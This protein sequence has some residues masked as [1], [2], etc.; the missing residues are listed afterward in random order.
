V[1]LTLGHKV[2]NISRKEG[3]D[4]ITW[5]KLQIN[6]LPEC[7]AVV[8]F[9]GMNIFEPKLFNEFFKQT[10]RSSRTITSKIL[11]NAIENAAKP[12]SVFISTSA[13]GSYKST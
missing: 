5:D 9:A 8:N 12:P 6:G 2:T 10:L 13:S 1:H 11:K 4:T 7:D 3:V